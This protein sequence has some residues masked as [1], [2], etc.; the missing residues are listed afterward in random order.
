MGSVSTPLW[1]PMSS[2]ET[3]QARHRSDGPSWILELSGEADT[4]TSGVVRAFVSH[5]GTI[6]D[7]DIVVDVS[8]LRFCDV[9]SAHLIMTSQGTR[10]VTVWGA[11]GSV[12]RVFD[13]L[14]AIQRERIPRFLPPIPTARDVARRAVSV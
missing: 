12:K 6:T 1:S 10:P 14:D 8:R 3:L 7:Q 13:L 11:T 4:A 5:M 9:A 2:C